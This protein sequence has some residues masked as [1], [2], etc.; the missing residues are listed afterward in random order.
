MQPSFNNQNTNP[1]M[2]G[3]KQIQDFPMKQNYQSNNQNYQSNNQNYQSNNQNL[4]NN[5]IKSNAG[6]KMLKVANNATHNRSTLSHLMNNNKTRSLSNNIDWSQ[7]NTN[8]N[9]M[10]SHNQNIE[11]LNDKL[12]NKKRVNNKN[13][14]GKK[15]KPMNMPQQQRNHQN[16]MMFNFIDRDCSNQG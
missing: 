3:I 2:Q 7:L 11:N 5:N 8:S 10:L 15:Q 4:Y 16:S 13:N 1:L 9:K 14:N 12:K 6:Q